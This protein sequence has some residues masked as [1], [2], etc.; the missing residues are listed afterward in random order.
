MC[1]VLYLRTLRTFNILAAF[2]PN[3]FGPSL[4]KLLFKFYKNLEKEQAL[5]NTYQL[6]RHGDTPTVLRHT[7]YHPFLTPPPRALDPWPDQH[8]KC[9]SLGHTGGDICP[10]YEFISS[11]EHHGCLS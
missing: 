5:P 6:Y 3:D 11:S 4:S 1:S 8:M 7:H 9:E 2:P 10:G